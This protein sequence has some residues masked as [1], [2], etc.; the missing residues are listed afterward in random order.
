MG[1]AQAARPSQ[2][3]PAAKLLPASFREV[4]VIKARFIE[5]SLYRAPCGCSTAILARERAR[6]QRASRKQSSRQ[7][8]FPS[9]RLGGLQFNLS[10]AEALGAQGEPNV[11][12]LTGRLND[13]QALAVIRQAF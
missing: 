3:A 12:G 9:R 8:R 5:N 6:L 2:A 10:P 1:L 7:N 13:G 4:Q 11:A